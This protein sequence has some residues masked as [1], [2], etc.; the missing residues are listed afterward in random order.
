MSHA[1]QNGH[2]TPRQPKLLLIGW[3][4]AVPE[5]VQRFAAAGRLPHAKRLMDGGSFR[6]LRSTIP[7][8]TACAWSSF[9]SGRNPGKHGLFE[10]VTPRKDSYAF[11]YTCG[12]HRREKNNDF[13]ALL[14]QGGFRVG[15][16]NVPMTYP[17]RPL[18]GF[19][20]AG[21]DAPDEKS[22]IALPKED[23]EAA[24]A[25]IG[26]PYR[27]D[28]RH[29]GN[30]RTNDD[31]EE[32]IREFIRVEKLRTDYTLAMMQRQ[33]IDVLVSVYNATDQVQHHFWHLMDTA[34]PQYPGDDNEEVR[35]FRDAI[36]RIYV[37]CDAELGRLMDAFPDANVM[38][39][40]D[41]GAGGTNGP[42]VRFNNAFGDAGLLT[43]AASKGSVVSN[44]VG[45]LDGFLRR[46][47]S[48]K[49]KAMLARMLPAGRSAI[50]AMALPP[51]DWARTTAFCYEGFTLSPS[52]WIN[53][54]SVFPQG[55]VGDGEEYEQALRRTEEALRALRDPHTGNPVIPNI[56]RARDI[57]PG[58][59]MAGAPDLILDWW[60]G[61]TF[62]MTRSHPSLAGKP[63]VFYPE[64]PAVPGQD[65]TGIHRWDGILGATGPAIGRPAGAP[66]AASLIDLAPTTL[67]LMGLSVPTDMDGKV[68]P[69]VVAG[70]VRI[71][72]TAA[73]PAGVADDE[74]A[75]GYSEEDAKRIE[76]RLSGLGYIE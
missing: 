21:L 60:S 19:M 34:H 23:W 30:M 45:W 39:I 59:Y 42:R 11:D 7:P 31:R 67:A 68:L 75:P 57:Y 69:D 41:H 62:T 22:G 12:G 48:A 6:P 51:I 10:F 3:D 63:T 46:T 44:F 72:Q 38:L 28:N 26:T 27:I 2:V 9:L 64:G 33:P 4:G 73:V 71:E 13:L 54:K 43:W 61:Q 76:E 65:I 58:K 36:E 53:R 35:R 47:L 24:H 16:V 5:L 1:S 20:I 55:T 14:N 52:V 25:T 18:D 32:A 74:A 29:L 40:S 66:C 15:V 50:E 49:T 37:A 8:V 17:P 56:H 70:A